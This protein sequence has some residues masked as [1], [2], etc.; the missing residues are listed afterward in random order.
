MDMNQWSDVLMSVVREDKQILTARQMAILIRVC[1]KN[2]SQTIR[3]LSADLNIPPPA[4]VRSVDRLEAFHYVK[5]YED[6][7]SMRSVLIHP[8][9]FGLTWLQNLK[10]KINKV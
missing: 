9:I 1:T 5:R 2:E 6:P 7:R 3:G 4:V 8:T 10:D